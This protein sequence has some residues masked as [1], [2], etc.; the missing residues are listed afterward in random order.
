[1]HMLVLF[2][3]VAL[4]AST[5]EEQQQPLSAAEKQ[6]ARLALQSP[7]LFEGDILGLEPDVD[8][9]AISDERL[10]WTNKIVPYVIDWSLSSSSNLIRQSMEAY[11]QTTCVKFVPRTNQRNYI[12]IFSGQGCYSYIGMLNQGAQEVSLGRG[13]VYKGTIIHE[14]GHALGFWHEQNRSDRDN[15]LT[16]YWNN[17]Q[18]GMS[19]Q[20]HLMKP[21]DNILYTPFDYGSIMIYG[22]YAFS[23]DGRSPTMVAKNGQ[24]LYEPYEKQGM[25]QSDITR[26]RKMYKC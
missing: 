6:E 11:H 15:Y 14:L 9:N 24:R 13:C 26:V 20:F 5:P 10:R 7:D 1:M 25:T 8:R 18:N 17:I 3:S 12:K 21:S 16:I 19:N 22:N 4:V 23:R 2:L